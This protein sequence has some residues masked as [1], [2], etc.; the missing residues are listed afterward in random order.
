[1]TPRRAWTIA[2]LGGALLGIG[3]GAVRELAYKDRVG[4]RTAQ[5]LSAVSLAGLLAGYFA[6]LQRRRP[7]P[8][9]RD[10]GAIGGTWLMLTVAFEFGFGRYVDRKPWDE[11]LK[12][13]DLRR[14]RVWPLVLAWIAAGPAVTRELSRR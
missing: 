10:A 1:M 12:D 3:N 5:Q 2:W 9:R 8:T 13:Y 4:E 14:G 6:F 11:L 7:I